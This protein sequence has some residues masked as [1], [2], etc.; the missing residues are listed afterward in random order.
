MEAVS[1]RRNLDHLEP[2]ENL[3]DYM[4][5]LIPFSITSQNKSIN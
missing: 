5:S 2:D 4:K 3:Y 1:T